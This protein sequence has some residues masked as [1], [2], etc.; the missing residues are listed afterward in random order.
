M[1]R[2]TDAGRDYVRE[3][4]AGGYSDAEIR[5]ALLNGGWSEQE[6]EL[7]LAEEAIPPAPPPPPRYEA[8][9]APPSTSPW[10]AA[11]IAC[12]VL[13]GLMLLTGPIM[14]AIL[15]PVFARAREKAREVTCMSNL[16]QISV[17]YLAYATDY[18]ETLPPAQQWP[19]AVMPY[20]DDPAGLQCP[21][22]DEPSS[23]RGWPLSYT[24][25]ARVAGV[26]LRDM[27]HP[28]ETILIYDG[29][30][31]CDDSGRSVAFRHVGGTNAGYV[32]GHV[33][34]LHEKNWATAQMEP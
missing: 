21:S 34:W 11:A 16:K 15:F 23:W 8:T 2:K 6:A 19:D 20:L 10:A 13:A 17:G 5:Q 30:Q 12:A 1:S 24:M 3:M 4:R 28:A 25:N 7:V 33:R 29:T 27:R 31:L 22:D 9:P 18:H 26:E 32:D 14:M